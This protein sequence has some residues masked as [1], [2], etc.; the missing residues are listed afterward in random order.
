MFDVKAD[1]LRELPEYKEVLS[2]LSQHFQITHDCLTKFTNEGLIEVSELEQTIATGQDSNGKTVKLKEIEALLREALPTLSSDLAMRLLGIFL[3]SQNGMDP[4]KRDEFF[5][6]ASLS[7]EQKTILLN[8]QHLGVTVDNVDVKN[9]S[10]K[11][12]FEKFKIA[13]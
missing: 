2:K 4:E 8:L 10:K 1:A 9:L 6:I 7:A 12:F 3:C 5:R 11:G 13:R